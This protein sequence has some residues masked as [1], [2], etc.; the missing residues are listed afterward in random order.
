MGIGGGNLHQMDWSFDRSFFIGEG[1]GNLKET[2]KNSSCSV[3]PYRINGL[4]LIVAN[5]PFDE[6]YKL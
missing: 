1:G 5:L 6:W 4:T 3:L 2:L